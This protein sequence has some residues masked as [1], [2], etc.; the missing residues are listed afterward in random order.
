MNT[1]SSTFNCVAG[2]SDHHAGL[3]MMLGAT[4]LGACLLEKGVF[5]DDQG[6]D[7]DVAHGMPVSQ[8]AG[9]L[10]QIEQLHTGLGDGSATYFMQ[11]HAA[12]MGWVAKRALPAD[13]AISLEDLTYAFPALG[14]KVEET[15]MALKWVLVRAKEAGE[16]IGWQDLRAPT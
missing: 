16:V 12:R 7:Q 6:M 14:V 1:L 2:L 5:L 11:G 15:P 3:E 13:Q 9:L 10:A 4:V 8:V